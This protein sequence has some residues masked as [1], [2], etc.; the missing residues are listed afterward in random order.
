MKSKSFG[1]PGGPVLA[2]DKVI[3]PLPTTVSSAPTLLAYVVLNP[4][5]AMLVVERLICKFGFV[6]VNVLA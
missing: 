5:G 1:P 6:K 2:V 4:S 3:A